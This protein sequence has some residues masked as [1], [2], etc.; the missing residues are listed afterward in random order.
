[1]ATKDITGKKFGK[2]TAINIAYR[3][4]YYTYW[5]C[6]C[7]CGNEK[8]VLLSNLTNGYT[9]SCGCAYKENGKRLKKYNK[10]VINGNIVE[11]ETSNTKN[12]FY[13]DLEDFDKIK[14]YCW[15]E[16][17][18]GYIANKY[19]SSIL[20]LHRLIMNCPSDKVVDHIDHNTLNN[21]K[22]NLRVC[23]QKEN[24][25]NQT[26][27]N[28]N[29]LKCYGISEIKRKNNI[30]YTVQLHGYKGCYKNFEDALKVRNQTIKEYYK[31]I[32][33][34]YDTD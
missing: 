10:Y 15:Y 20:L 27:K 13:V 5:N 7:D 29:K 8:I 25:M 3:K 18:Q 17:K 21:C 22:K 19:T 28:D 23:S 24:A 6:K 2:L 34:N 4:K 30:Y 1:M 32:G 33:R 11:V 16:T 14:D 26:I 31:S 12:K 9:K